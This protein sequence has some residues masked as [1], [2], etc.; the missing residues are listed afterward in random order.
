[1]SVQ[2]TAAQLRLW[3]L[4]TPRTLNVRLKEL[5]ATNYVIK[6]LLPVRKIGLLLGDSGLG[7]SPL[8]YQ[9]AIC[10][11]A[12]IPF[13]GKQITQGPVVIADYENG[14]ADM[15]DLV[16]RIS[17]YL[18]LPE[19]PENLYLW[20]LNDCPPDGGVWG[21]RLA[22]IVGFVKPVLTVVDSLAAYRPTAEEKNSSATELLQEFRKMARDC[23]TAVLMVHHRRKQPRKA[24]ESAGPLESANVRMWFQDARGASALVNSS[25]IRLGVDVPDT[26]HSAKDE[27]ALVLRGFGRVRGD[28]GPFFLSRDNDENDDPAGYRVLVGAEL[29]DPT[30]Q[31]ALLDLPESFQ[32]KDAKRIFGR[33]D[34]ATTNFLHDCMNLG[35]V[36]KI[37]RGKYQ[38]VAQIPSNDGAAGEQT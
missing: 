6:G 14:L 17:R 27:V 18:K 37:G 25:D 26:A 31:R 4:H 3:G 11:A 35:L 2:F 23:G 15:H 9:A 16:D 1:V 32:F 33:A 5:G 34:Q 29:L 24:E 36:E 22:D 28:I 21:Y 7:K 19:P 30:R 13:L 12:G 20:S 38:K 8:V 10:V